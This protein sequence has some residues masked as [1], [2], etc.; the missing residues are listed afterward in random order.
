MTNSFRSTKWFIYPYAAFLVIGAILMI[1]LPKNEIHLHLNQLN[2]LW[3]D[4]F[5]KIFTHLG[6]GIIIA[7]AIIILLFVRYRYAIILALSSIIATIAVQVLKRFIFEDIRRPGVFFENTEGFHLVDG[8]KPIV[9]YSFPSGH[10]AT[11]FSI[12]LLFALISEKKTF[13]LAF[14]I[15]AFLVAYSRIYLSQHYL[16][17]VYFGS[18]IGSLSTLFM[19]LWLKTYKNTSFDNSLASTFILKK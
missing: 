2:H 9:A 4:W 1:S 14:F 13:Q 11:A 18:L 3:A 17:D 15:T 16:V 6:D 5:F 8:V 19:F 10:S 7:L 12:F